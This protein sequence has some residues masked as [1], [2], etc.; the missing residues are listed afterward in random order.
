MYM[1]VYMDWL[2]SDTGYKNTFGCFVPQKLDF[3]LKF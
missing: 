2:A 1:S 3:N